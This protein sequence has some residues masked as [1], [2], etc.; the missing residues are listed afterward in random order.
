[1]GNS[2][3]VRAMCLE[4]TEKA[5]AEELSANDD[6]EHREEESRTSSNRMIEHDSF[7]GKP[8]SEEDAE[9]HGDE[10][11]QSKKMHR[12]LSVLRQE[13]HGH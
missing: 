8:E 1:M 6:K 4:L 10:S 2:R 9:R 13:D 7:E 3:R 11:G 12:S 5:Q